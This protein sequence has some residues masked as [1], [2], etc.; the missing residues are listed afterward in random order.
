M[1]EPRILN[2]RT[3][4]ADPAA[5]VLLAC[6]GVALH[7]LAQGAASALVAAVVITALV[8]LAWTALDARSAD[9]ALHRN[10]L[11]AR[12]EA[13]GRGAIL[14]LRAARHEVGA[15]LSARLRLRTPLVRPPVQ[16]CAP[17]AAWTALPPS[18]RRS[19]VH[20]LVGARAALQAV[21]S[22]VARLTQ[23]LA[24]AY[25]VTQRR[26]LCPRLDVMSHET[27]ASLVAASTGE[28]VALKD[29]RAPRLVFI[30]PHRTSTL[31]LLP[32]VTGV[33]FAS[34]EMLGGSPFLRLAAGRD[35]LHQPRPRLVILPRRLRAAATLGRGVRVREVAGARAVDTAAS[36]D[37]ARRDAKGHAAGLAGSLDRH[38]G[39]YNGATA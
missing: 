1:G 39:N 35:T 7:L 15:A 10:A 23:R 5:L 29:G 33:R 38:I 22:V 12:C 6:F 16:R 3:A 17:A 32:L 25:V 13:A 8:Y 27:P 30:P 34:L 14:L 20:A 37:G 9:G 31:P 21:R 24:V 28:P 4:H 26:G 36:L 19:A 18:L 2:T 11:P